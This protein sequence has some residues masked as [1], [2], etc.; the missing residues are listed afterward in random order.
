MRIVKMNFFTI[1]AFIIYF[2]GAGESCTKVSFMNLNLFFIIII[3]LIDV[4]FLFIF[5]N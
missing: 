5:L 3:F 4:T 1:S 2:S